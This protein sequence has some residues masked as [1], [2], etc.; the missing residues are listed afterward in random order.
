[1]L[2]DNQI[3][4]YINPATQKP[5]KYYTVTAGAGA[6]AKAGADTQPPPDSTAPNTTTTSQPTLST[7]AT[8][9]GAY[10]VSQS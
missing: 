7:K 4:M 6:A 10:S 2:H 8:K 3:D 9:S 1:M 5:S